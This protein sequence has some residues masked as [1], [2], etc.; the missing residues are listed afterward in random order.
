[1]STIR[2]GTTTTTALQT[3]GDTTGNIV[4]QP[5]SG[6]VTC[7]AV[8]ALGIPSGT[9]AERPASP[10][11]GQIR[12]NT[13][14]GVNEIYQAGQWIQF[15][16]SSAPSV[17]YLVVAGGGGGGNQHGGGGGGGGFLSGSVSVSANTTY[18]ITVGAGGGGAATTGG[19]NA[20][21]G[22]SGSNSTFGSL[23]NSTTGAVGG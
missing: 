8:G 9:T 21:K 14:L 12:Y 16:T 10:Q 17:S 11:N 6:L 1:M 15:A 5:D 2:A 20:P 7:N 19:P 23:V 18:S 4:L 3:T 13:S 22:S